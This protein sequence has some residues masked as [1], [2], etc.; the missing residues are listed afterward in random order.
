MYRGPSGRKHI[1]AG[2][3]CPHSLTRTHRGN[4]PLHTRTHT[5]DPDP[6]THHTH[7]QEDRQTH[8]IDRHTP[9]PP[10]VCASR[11]RPATT[12]ACRTRTIHPPI[13][14]TKPF[15]D[16]LP[17]SLPPQLQSAAPRHSPLTTLPLL[18]LCPQ[19]H[20]SMKPPSKTLVT[21]ASGDPEVVI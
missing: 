8:E 21:H 7:A 15:P 11:D 2:C 20:I 16:H 10:V 3:L 12:T 14:R 9:L 4:R 1:E 19:Y 6:H 18:I 5:P 17:P 13:T